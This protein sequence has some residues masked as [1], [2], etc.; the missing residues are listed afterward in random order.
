MHKNVISNNYYHFV[1]AAT[2]TLQNF[3]PHP[4]SDPPLRVSL[5]DYTPLG[6]LR[7]PM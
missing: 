5:D 4:I 6:S 1:V 3:G 7:E 2:T